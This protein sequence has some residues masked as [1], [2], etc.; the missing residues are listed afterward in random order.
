MR[1]FPIPKRRKTIE[2]GQSPLTDLRV[3]GSSAL[4]HA[5][6]VLVASFTIL[7]AAMPL[8]GDI[9]ASQGAVHRARSGGQPGEHSPVTRRGGR[10]PW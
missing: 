1:A 4:F 2:L 5:L 7:N 9:D 6:V 10:K 8:G 3:L